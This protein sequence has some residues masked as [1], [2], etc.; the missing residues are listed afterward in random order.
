MTEHEMEMEDILT[1]M[2]TA[3]LDCF[4][5]YVTM[6]VAYLVTA[7]FVGNRLAVQQAMIISVLF[8]TAAIVMTWGSFAFLSRAIPV[9]NA[10]ETMHTDRIYG[11]QPAVRNITV[12]IMGFGIL[13]CLKFMWDVRHFR[14]E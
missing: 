4:G 13:A 5:M 8:V 6:L 1:G 12:A 11:A 14:T 3:A 2:T 9:A 7:Y 10:L